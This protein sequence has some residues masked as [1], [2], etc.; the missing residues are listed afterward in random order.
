ME[1]SLII[2]KIYI[3]DYIINTTLLDKSLFNLLVRTLSNKFYKTDKIEYKVEHILKKIDNIFYNNSGQKIFNLAYQPFNQENIISNYKRLNFNKKWI[4]PIVNE[5]K[6]L[7]QKILEM[8]NDF[9]YN[10]ENKLLL[11]EVDSKFFYNDTEFN[12][13]SDENY[14]ETSDINFKKLL[15]TLLNSAPTEYPV[16]EDENIF[17]SDTALI[18]S[19][20]C[21]IIREANEH[22]YYISCNNK[23]PKGSKS[24]VKEI[25]N[26]FNQVRNI[27]KNENINITKFLILNP[28]KLLTSNYNIFIGN[29]MSFLSEILY[30]NNNIDININ[31][32][33]D[34]IIN[35]SQQILNQQ[36]FFTLSDSTLDYY[37]VTVDEFSNEYNNNTGYIWNYL[38]IAQNIEQ[39]SKN[40]EIKT[41]KILKHIY[42]LFGYD[43]NK[44]PFCY[45]KYLKNILQHNISNYIVKHVISINSPLLDLY[46][47]YKNKKNTEKNTFTQAI[48]K[49]YNIENIENISENNLYT[50]LENNT[51]DKGALFYLTQYINDYLNKNP[52]LPS[53]IS[54]PNLDNTKSIDCENYRLVKTYNSFNE[55]ENDT[56][57]F[58]DSEYSKL[59]YLVEYSDLIGILNNEDHIYNNTLFELNSLVIL[60]NDGKNKLDVKKDNIT[61]LSKSIFNTFIK[62]NKIYL[63]NLLFN[64]S[65]FDLDILFNKLSCFKYKNKHYIQIP[66]QKIENFNIIYILNDSTFYYIQ[67]DTLIPIKAENDIEY[68]NQQYIEKCKSYND[69]KIEIDNLKNKYDFY[70]SL[71]T[72]E[73]THIK[74]TELYLNN[75]KNKNEFYTEILN[76]TKDIKKTE[77]YFKNLPFI[78]YTITNYDD[79][80]IYSNFIEDLSNLNVKFDKLNLDE[81]KNI[82]NE[83]DKISSSIENIKFIDQQI[84]K[85]PNSNLWTSVHRYINEYEI[86]H[87]H[88]IE[89]P[90]KYTRAYYKMRELLVD[91]DIIRKPNF[92]L[93]SL[94]EAPGFFVNCIKDLVNNSEWVD[95]KIYTWLLDSDTTEQRNFWKSFENHIWGANSEGP[96]DKTNI[97]GD[98]TDIEQI[99]K[100]INDVGV[101]K[102]DLITADGGKEKITDTD[103]ILEEYN[104]FSLFL[105]EIIIALF[106]QKI[107]GTFILKMYDIS[108]VNSINLL[109]ILNYFYTSVKIIKPY[110]SRPCNSEKYIKCEIFRGFDDIAS[111]TLEKIKT[112]LFEL[113][114]NSKNIK[115]EYKYANI[116]ENFNLDNTHILKFNESII[117]KT[118]ELYTQHIYDILKTKD[119]QDIHLITTYFKDTNKINNILENSDDKTKGYFITKIKNCIRLGQYL[120][121][122]TEIK[123]LYINFYKNNN[124]NH[125]DFYTSNIYP[126]HFKNKY[127]IDREKN[128]YEKTP[129]IISFVKKYCILFENFGQNKILDEKILRTTYLFI[130]NPKIK[131]ITH[132][133]IQSI[134]KNLNNQ[135][136]LYNILINLCKKQNISTT[137]NLYKTNTINII[138]KY[139]NNIRHFIGWYLCKYTY[140]PMFPRYMIYD[141]IEDQIQECGIKVNSHQYICCYSGDKLD[142]EDF[143]DFMGVGDSIHRTTINLNENE[144]DESSEKSINLKKITLIQKMIDEKKINDIIKILDIQQH[145][146]FHI[147]YQ[148]F[149]IKDAEFIVNCISNSKIIYKQ[150][151]LNDLLTEY[152]DYFNLLNDQYSN[153]KDMKEKKTDKITSRDDYLKDMKYWKK[154][155]IQQV[156]Q[157]KTIY[158]MNLHINPDHLNNFTNPLIK[159]INDMFLSKNNILNYIDKLNIDTFTIQHL[160]HL[161]FSEYI[162]TQYLNTILYTLSYIKLHSTKKNI[163]KTYI[164]NEKNFLIYLFKNTSEFTIFKNQ[165]INDYIM[166]INITKPITPLTSIEDIKNQ[167]EEQQINTISKHITSEWKDFSEKKFNDKII[168]LQNSTTVIDFLKEC[169]KINNSLYIEFI[170]VLKNTP[171]EDIEFKSD[172]KNYIP[173]TTFTELFEE[174]NNIIMGNPILSITNNIENNIKHNRE[175]LRDYKILDYAKIKN[176]FY[177]NFYYQNKTTNLNYTYDSFIYYFKYLYLNVYEKESEFYGQKRY[178]KKNEDNIYF[179]IYT[180]KTKKQILDEINS[181]PDLKQIYDELLLNKNNILN[182][183]NFINKNTLLNTNIYSSLINNICYS[184]SLNNIDILYKY[185]T[186]FYNTLET[187]DDND[188]NIIMR[189]YND[190]VDNIIKFLNTYSVQFVSQYPNLKDII[191]NIFVLNEMESVYS[192]VIKLDIKNQSK[193]A[194]DI[195]KLNKDLIIKIKSKNIDLDI[196]DNLSINELINIIQNIKQKISY[197]SNFSNESQ[198]FNIKNIENDLKNKYKFIRNKYI[199]ESAEYISLINLV[200]K[201]Y[202]FTSLDE[203]VLNTLQV[204]FNNLLEL[205]N[206]YPNNIVFSNNSGIDKIMLLHKIYQILNNCFDNLDSEIPVD[207]SYFKQK[208]YLHSQDTSDNNYLLEQNIS[209]EQTDTVTVIDRY[210]DLFKVI[211]NDT[212]KSISEY[213]TIINEYDTIEDDGIEND[214][215]LG[216]VGF[217]DSI[218]G[219]VED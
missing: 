144:S 98:L 87:T 35:N 141:N 19:I 135:S 192:Q 171:I 123:P 217:L 109:H 216:N 182:N 143:D 124:Y 145:I 96:T 187:T 22:T 42:N 194:E 130:T 81:L 115:K 119:S 60:D 138:I 213:S 25:K 106:T 173:N 188:K 219:S 157:K 197:I 99:E 140:I 94:A 105:G 33:I 49:I 116:F 23:L 59:N 174:I 181:I 129:K 126:P 31:N 74:D 58:V 85:L 34:K 52:K 121:L 67:E 117:V 179:C 177:P 184:F 176:V 17:S 50:Y 63:Y 155:Q 166:D 77:I 161:Y 186:L 43:L 20:D 202:N 158:F 210:K 91:D 11:S 131:E 84:K 76:R 89:N 79:K 29:T 12:P 2:K 46:N 1:D 82:I 178:F 86:F 38:K 70:E 122:T 137:F 93:I 71:H 120:K 162:Y 92:R 114:N 118:R 164:A 69:K 207:S 13:Y 136:E 170:N 30:N 127:E 54:S 88:I 152:N 180:N 142:K 62:D 101:N 148:I 5:K 37:T 185:I 44:I 212:I 159:N 26:T 53:K 80:T 73:T 111:A 139:Q 83:S 68:I 66:I 193:I 209:F 133:L 204:V 113:L 150:S 149:N 199:T 147:L 72:L 110:T 190:P 201:F 146:C 97:T 7:N 45:L 203:Y 218:E 151:P 206:F 16:F 167:L 215:N 57:N 154:R 172:F 6:N 90:N 21:K 102:A 41:I 32:Y 165:M 205:F 153:L 36:D 40:N 65:D 18:S 10:N 15:I 195:T 107:G 100:I 4:I 9:K 128:P 196:L 95:Y 125:K 28:I 56:N 75:L 14:F 163:L 200:I 156:P 8:T 169:N 214:D 104:H 47:E 55:Y 134:E 189:F 64:K 39:I 103:Y 183:T 61:E 27:L 211:V 108:Y 51:P 168:Q 48:Q 160:L 198:Q 191:D 132:P 78:E 175:D 3:N 112:N 24:Y 208:F